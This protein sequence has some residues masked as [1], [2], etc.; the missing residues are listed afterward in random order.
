MK[1]LAHFIVHHKLAVLL[2]FGGLLLLSL[3]MLL[4][5]NVN[6]DLTSYLP[7]NA[8]TMIAI[9]TVREEF[10][11]PGTAALMVEDISIPDALAF[12]AELLS[13]DGV[14]GV[15]WLDDAADLR[16][17]LSVQDQALVVRYYNDG[18]ALY[19]L[20]FW[21]NGYHSR[22]VAALAEEHPR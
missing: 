8:D 17:P 1:K 6:Y 15:T 11:Y 13:V 9:G 22:T 16:A 18:A 21:E 19:Q 14:S 3:V 20:A 12:K 10:G 2:G 7:K 5:V 4:F